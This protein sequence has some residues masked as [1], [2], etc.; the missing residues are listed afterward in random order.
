M[1]RRMKVMA[2]VD[3]SDYSE[4]IIR[5]SGLMAMKLNADL[6]LVNVINQ[7]DLDMI[8]RTMISYESFSYQDYLSGQEEDR[9]AKMEDLIA[10]SC[11][12]TIHCRYLIRTGV[13]YHE[14]LD[15]IE[16]EGPDL[17]V[18]GKKGRTNLVDVLVGSTARKLYRTSPVPL[19]TI[20]AGFDDKGSER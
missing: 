13:P 11:P 6:I 14:L 2:A 5:Y 7:R 1:T 4:T 9:K 3:L 20:P 15:A 16:S 18:V 10:T 8:H 12:D 17:M 19:L